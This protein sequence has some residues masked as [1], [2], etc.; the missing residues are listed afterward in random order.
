M[1]MSITAKELAKQLNISTASVS[2]ALNNKPGVSTATRKMVLEA[3]RKMGYDFS[4]T[5]KEGK[6]SGTIYY[7]RYI[8]YNSPQEAPFFGYLANSL[9]KMIA[10]RGYKY[11]SMKVFEDDEFDKKLNGIKYSDCAGI[12]LLGTDITRV[13]L[14]AFLSLGLPLVLMDNWFDSPSVNCVKGNNIQGA[15]LATEYLIKKYK[16]QPGY[17][18]SSLQLYNY[19]ERYLGYCKA[20]ETYRMSV[21]NSDI[22][23]TLPNMHGA[24]ADMFEV[25]QER[26]NFSRCYLADTDAQAVGAM[27]A[28]QAKGIK[29]PDDVALIGFD[30]SFYSEESKPGLTSIEPYPSSMASIALERLL[31]IIG[32]RNVPPVK[33]EI[34]TSLVE[35]G[36]A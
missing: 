27:M 14:E 7:I 32:D 31:N 30:N 11:K 1:G 4:S 3:A 18:Q 25:M 33:I 9:D 15:Y 22:I 24:Q 20:L 12:L 36:S 28:F 35:R 21:R 29:I 19:T 23:V 10:E 17:L 8:N 6:L 34:G 2:V 5:T 13:R 26:D 16:C